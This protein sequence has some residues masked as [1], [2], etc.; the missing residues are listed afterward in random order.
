M[1]HLFQQIEFS[2]ENHANAYRLPP[3]VADVLAVLTHGGG[4][5]SRLPIRRLD[6]GFAEV[7][8]VHSV[9]VSCPYIDYHTNL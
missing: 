8:S 1:S 2:L 4:S 6:E 7:R 9:P 5:S 3:I